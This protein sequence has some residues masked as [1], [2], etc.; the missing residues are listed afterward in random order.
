MKQVL[1]DIWAYV[2]SHPKKIFLLALAGVLVLWV[3]F[4]NYGVVARF[5]MEAENR[6]LRELQEQEELKI[7]EN[8][9]KIRSADNPET[10]EK[11]AR[12]KYNFSKDD[13]TLFII[14]DKKK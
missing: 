2:L 8:T 6:M 3:I 13:E 5:R 10:I 1:S 9:R 14:E 12:E 11:I 7:I 4:G